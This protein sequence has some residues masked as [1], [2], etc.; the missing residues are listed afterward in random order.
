MASKRATRHEAGEPLQLLHMLISSPHHMHP[1][2][3]FPMIELT[4]LG[5]IARVVAKWAA[6]TVLFDE[7]VGE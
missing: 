2:L 3:Q 4:G 6:V 7:C 1:K 5:V